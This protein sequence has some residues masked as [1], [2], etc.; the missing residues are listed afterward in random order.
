MAGN[1]YQAMS[2]VQKALAEQGISKDGTNSFQNY[3]F[4]GIDQVYKAL[5][6]L[7]H[8]HGLLVIPGATYNSVESHTDDKG[9]LITH[10]FLDVEYTF[11]SVEDG[12]THKA[13]IV[14][15]A[16]DT[17]GD[18]ASNKALSAA[19][20]YG[21][22]QTFAIPVEGDDDADSSSPQARGKTFPQ[23]SA[24]GDF[25]SKKQLDYLEQLIKEEEKVDKGIGDKVWL[26]LGNDPKKAEVGKAIDQLV[27]R[28]KEREDAT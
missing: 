9:R 14:G 11:V 19:Y 22:I 28:Q 13:T 20:K 8:E 12:S 18:K 3:S 21:M 10:V 5:A 27:R 2:A 23:Q 4:R 24:G 26:V 7:L 1:V 17:A 16:M 6:P 15:E 25:P